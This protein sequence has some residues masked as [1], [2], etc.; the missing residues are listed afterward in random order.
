MKNSCALLRFGVTD[1]HKAASFGATYANA[2]W[3]KQDR[4]SIEEISWAPNCRILARASIMT[5]KRGTGGR[6]ITAGRRTPMDEPP[7]API[8]GVAVLR[9]RCRFCPR[10]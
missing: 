6:F 7:L 1:Q 10:T 4:S 5:L 3:G 2:L 9:C 8:R